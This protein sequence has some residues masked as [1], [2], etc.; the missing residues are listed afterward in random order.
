MKLR[1]AVHVGVRKLI[2]LMG[3]PKAV[4]QCGSTVIHTREMIF[5]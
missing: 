5:K 2:H 3:G 1:R 4:Q